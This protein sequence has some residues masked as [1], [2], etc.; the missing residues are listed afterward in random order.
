MSLAREPTLLVAKWR[1]M[2]AEA[3]AW[4]WDRG[5]KLHDLKMADTECHCRLLLAIHALDIACAH[6]QPQEIAAAGKAV[7]AEWKTVVAFMHRRIAEAAQ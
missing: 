5:Y 4:F 3:S 6:E 7:V 2:E 1:R